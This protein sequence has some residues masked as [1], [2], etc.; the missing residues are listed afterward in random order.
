MEEAKVAF[1]VSEKKDR[2]EF[3]IPLL[4]PQDTLP[5]IIETKLFLLL[6][7]P[8]PPDERPPFPPRIERRRRTKKH[9]RTKTETEK[10]RSCCPEN[11]P[12]KTFWGPSLLGRTDGDER[13]EEEEAGISL[14]P[15]FPPPT[16]NIT[17]RF[18]AKRGKE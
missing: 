6:S 17:V 5:S 8:L 16:Y 12:Q 18:W 15:P 7:F 2:G 9:P 14:S 11:P 13:E 1:L 3:P 4:S 10:G